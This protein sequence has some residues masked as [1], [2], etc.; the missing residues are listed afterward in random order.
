MLTCWPEYWIDDATG[1]TVLI[2]E[3]GYSQSYPFRLF[4]EVVYS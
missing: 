1:V 3:F 2:E 4:G